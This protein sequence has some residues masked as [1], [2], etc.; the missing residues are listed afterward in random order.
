VDDVAQEVWMDVFRDLK[1]LNDPAAFLS[2][3]Y[4]VARNRAFWLLRRQ[5]TPIG[6]IDEVESLVAAE[7]EPDFTA[8]DA[9]AVHA[10]LGQLSLEHREVLLLRFMDELS[11][12]EIAAV[13]GC[14]VGTV[15]SRIHNAKRQL[16]I[17]IQNKAGQP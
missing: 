17:I 7:E 2:W 11:Y 10:A 8:A 5:G 13:A 16:R 14:H 15:R 3:L 6:S 12:E 1:N 9:Q 4:R